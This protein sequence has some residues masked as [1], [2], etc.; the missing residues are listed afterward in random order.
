MDGHGNIYPFREKQDRRWPG[1]WPEPPL[2]LPATPSD[3]PGAL[4]PF[5]SWAI[6]VKAAGDQKQGGLVVRVEIS[7]GCPICD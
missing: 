1:L 6:D 5:L 7:R 4:A 2:S 3:F